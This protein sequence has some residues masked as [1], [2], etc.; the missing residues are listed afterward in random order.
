MCVRMDKPWRRGCCVDS[1]P[2]RRMHRE[3]PSCSARKQG[4]AAASRAFRRVTR[5][6]AAWAV[7]PQAQRL[8]SIWFLPGSRWIPVKEADTSDGLLGSLLALTYL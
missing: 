1:P 2:R 8:S 7:Q 5:V 3:P 4:W 6:V